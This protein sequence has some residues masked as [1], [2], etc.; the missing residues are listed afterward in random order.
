M[1]VGWSV[2]VN[3][4]LLNDVTITHDTNT[5]TR[6]GRPMHDP[7]VEHVG[8]FYSRYECTCHSI[9]D[10]TDLVLDFVKLKVDW[11]NAEKRGRPLDVERYWVIQIQ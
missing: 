2:I 3:I 6:F 9:P 1:T 11:R 10:P 4:S 5:S 7:K 8:P